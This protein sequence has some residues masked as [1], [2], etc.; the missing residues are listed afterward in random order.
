[1]KKYLIKGAL[2]LFSGGLLFSCAEKES[3]YVPLAQQKVK[4]FE[5]VF[6][7]IYGDNI[8][9]YQDWGFKGGNTNLDP[10]DESIYIDVVDAGG[11]IAFTR[12]GAFGGKAFLAFPNRTRT[13]GAY[14]NANMWADN[15]RVPPEL[16]NE[17]KDLVR[18]YF[19]QNPQKKYED[20]GWSN[21]FVQQVYKGHTN[22]DGSQSQEQYK[23]A[24]WTQSNPQYVIGSDHMDHLCAVYED[25]V[26]QDHIFNYNFGT[27]SE[28]PNV[29]NSEGV[30]YYTEGGEAGQ[31][32]DRIQLMTSSTTANFGYFNSD[33]TVGH[34]DKTCLVSW[35][36]IS[37]WAGIYGT[38]NDILADGWNR[39]FMGFDFEQVIGDDIYVL[40]D[41]N[42]L[43][44]NG[45]IVYIKNKKGETVPKKVPV[46][47]KISDM[48]PAKD[49]A[50]D[51]EKVI[52]L[53]DEIKN[54]YL[55]YTDNNG[56]THK[57]PLLVEQTNEYCGVNGDIDGNSIYLK[58]QLPG[59]QQIDD[60][61][62]LTIFTNKAKNGELPVVNSTL[63]KWVK[64][65]GGADGYYSDWIVTLTEAQ[66][67]EFNDEQE[68]EEERWVVKQDGRVFC[69]DLGRAT[70]EDLDFNDV[71]FDVYIWQKTSHTKKYRYRY[72]DKE[73]TKQIGDP[74]LIYDSGAQ[75]EYF[76]QVILQ[77]AGGTIPVSLR[78]GKD[79]YVIHDQFNDPEPTPTD[80][81]VNTRDNNSSAYGSFGTRRPVQLGN[82]SVTKR[83]F[84]KINNTV[85]EDDDN[86]FT[87]K[88]IPGVS[89][90]S[91]IAIWTLFGGKE[92][93]DVEELTS[94]IGE[95][96]QKFMAPI[97]TKWASERKN[98]S[99]AYPGF[100]AWVEDGAKEPWD[101]P[102]DD[103]TYNPEVPYQE[104]EDF[105][106][107]PYA[108][109]VK[110]SYSINSDRILWE[111][112]D[113]EKEN[114][115]NIF[116]FN[117]NWSLKK[118]SNI[119]V[120][121]VG[122][123]SAG[124][125]IRIYATGMPYP[126]NA[127]DFTS[128]DQ[129]AWI[130]IVIGSIQPYFVDQEFPNYEFEDGH[131]V[132][133]DSGCLEVVLDEYAAQLLNNQIDNAGNM[134]MEI[135]GRNFTLTS[136]CVAID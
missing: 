9:P 102:N 31:H 65:Q 21:Y 115:D 96:P 11:D 72:S 37:Q 18:R 80:M 55:T 124:N 58:K 83:S 111:P 116:G 27:C 93:S 35:K 73:K 30:E 88:F 82:Q 6:K 87:F 59:S 126:E 100:K 78:V 41:Q 132:Y 104:G 47:A 46:Y 79:E 17:Q 5:D 45:N 125:R 95:A 89:K 36:T 85:V 127:G 66:G 101:A 109:R 128:D 14:P 33:G 108:M 29:Q 136:I 56:K 114:G 1:M 70:R 77:A 118:I 71:V 50:W 91:D 97:P 98:I 122:Q 106:H 26:T 134:T 119:N 130:T 15:F 60:V 52:K 28:N 39:S 53:T 32:R 123:F 63:L 94:K 81:M 74:E 113:A 75:E 23:S 42:D 92:G 61:I 24:N 76:A 10:T 103:Y 44:E 13:A 67:A 7:E 40:S 12:A 105:L 129:K 25:E 19:Q 34:I 90:I 38:E 135:Q 20:P 69:E 86:I 68:I 117:T 99:L 4:A 57:V 121:N 133:K 62:D 43:D 54:S 51:G 16:T 3:E 107:M 112:T 49:W 64:V 110:R 131:K 48:S 2:A 22:L 120:S 8:D 84:K